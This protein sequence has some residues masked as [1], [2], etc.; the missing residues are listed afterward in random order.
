MTIEPRK[1]RNPYSKEPASSRPTSQGKMT[2]RRCARNSREERNFVDAVG[3]AL[4]RYSQAHAEEI[5]RGREERP[6]FASDA[7]MKEKERALMDSM[8]LK[9]KGDASFPC[10][11][12]TSLSRGGRALQLSHKKK[13]KGGVFIA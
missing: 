2:A 1:D 10:L 12:R 11:K 9:R 4:S 5:R 13:E 6:D 7:T 8:L 3:I